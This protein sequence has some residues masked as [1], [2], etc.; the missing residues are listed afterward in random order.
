V[1]EIKNF[2]KKSFLDVAKSNIK[3]QK[4]LKDNEVDFVISLLDNSYELVELAAK[5][6][7][8]LTKA[9]VANFMVQ[10][11]LA[12]TSLSNSQLVSCGTSIVSLATF[13]STP[14][15]AAIGTPIGATAYA[16][17]LAL[18]MLDVGGNCYLAY[19]DFK[20]DQILS[21]PSKHSIPSKEQAYRMLELETKKQCVPENWLE[22]IIKLEESDPKMCVQLEVS[23]TLT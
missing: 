17:L 19:Q 20:V 7:G 15:S 12:F 3:K 8:A 4:I 1:G 13:L 23:L 22:K 9:D 11:G 2:G 18:E 14:K 10:R 6:N 16:S 5:K 21:N